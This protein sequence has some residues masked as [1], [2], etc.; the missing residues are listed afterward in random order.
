VPEVVEII[1]AAGGVAILAHPQVSFYELGQDRRFVDWRAGVSKTRQALDSFVDAGLD[2]VEV[3]NYRHGPEFRAEI[4]DWAQDKSLLITAGTDIIRQ[5]A[6][7]L[8]AL[9]MTAKSRF[10][11]LKLNVG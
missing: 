2:G 1:H 9:F 4:L 8:V 10:L 5:Q 3:F 11:S 6:K 7:I